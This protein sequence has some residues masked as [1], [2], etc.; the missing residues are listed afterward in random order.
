MHQARGVYTIVFV[1]Y[2]IVVAVNTIVC[3]CLYTAP[4]WLYTWFHVYTMRAVM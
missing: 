1:V 2:T 3:V 4:G